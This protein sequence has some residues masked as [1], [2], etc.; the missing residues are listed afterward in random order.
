MSNAQF[1][2]LTVKAVRE[3]TSEARTFVFSVPSELESQFEYQQGQYLTLRFQINGEDLRRAYS[4]CSSPLEEDLAVTVKRV[5]D[6]KVSTHLHGSVQ[7]GDT[8]EVMPPQG[9]FFTKLQEGQ[10]KD[11]FLFGAGSGIT[12]LMSILKTVLEKEPMSS[13]YLLYG[14]RTEESIIYREELAALQQQYEGQLHVHHILSQP[15]RNRAKGLSGL[16]GRGSFSWDGLIGRIDAAEVDRF[17]A[18][19]PPSGLAAE[20]FICGPGAMIDNVE[21]ALQERGVDKEHIHSERFLTADKNTATTEAT[22][23]TDGAIIVRLNGKTIELS[24]KPGQTIL[25]ALMEQK[26]DPPY[27]CLS[28]ACSTCLAKVQKGGVRMDVCYALDEEEVE[29]GYILTCQSHPT[30]DRVEITFDV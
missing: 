1:Y 2:P 23:S 12:P 22:T 30:T 19:F 15:R 9:R 4:M 16:F 24:L 7:Q 17:L 26:Y 21:K 20:Y 28:G 18:H 5:K 27:S 10:R 29:E 8:I 13:V 6:G 11:Y 25:D 3:E 14:N